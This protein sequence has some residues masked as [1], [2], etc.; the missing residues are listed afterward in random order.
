MIRT[1]HIDDS[2]SKAKALLEFLRTFDFV[3]EEESEEFVLSA[4]HKKILDRRVE[5]H[6]SGKSETF[7][8]EEVQAYVR[9]K[10]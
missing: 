4:E 6:L 8:W 3:K 5:N 10:K 9:R 2:S 7:S 1:I